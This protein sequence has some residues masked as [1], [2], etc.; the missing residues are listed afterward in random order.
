MTDEFTKSYFCVFI[1]KKCNL[2]LVKEKKNPRIEIYRFMLEEKK[3]NKSLAHLFSGVVGVV[4]I[5]IS[6]VVTHSHFPVSQSSLFCV[7]FV[8]LRKNRVFYSL[9]KKSKSQS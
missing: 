2:L 5:S 3:N 1:K 7:V 8:F 6:S 9:R 4:G